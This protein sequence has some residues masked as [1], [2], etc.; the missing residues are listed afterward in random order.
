MIRQKRIVKNISA[1]VPFASQSTTEA[2][3]TMSVSKR[4]GVIAISYR[5]A[6]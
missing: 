5:N 1:Y 4:Y 2:I 3:L 6:V